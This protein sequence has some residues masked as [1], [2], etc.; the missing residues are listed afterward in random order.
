[1]KYVVATSKDFSN[2]RLEETFMQAS[3]KVKDDRI[4]WTFKSRREMFKA[5]D[6]FINAGF[7]SVILYARRI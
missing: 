6:V 2:V 4:E 3:I 5:V 1:M 7:S